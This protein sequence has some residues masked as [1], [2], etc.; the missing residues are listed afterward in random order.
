MGFARP[1][2]ATR[3][4]VEMPMV[5]DSWRICKVSPNNSIQLIYIIFYKRSFFYKKRYPPPPEKMTKIVKSSKNFIGL[6]I[7]VRKIAK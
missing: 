1:S 7:F 2:M 3:A 5:I 6:A 4:Q